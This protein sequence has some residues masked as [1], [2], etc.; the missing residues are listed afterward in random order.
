VNDW[1]LSRP[2]G[3]FPTWQHKTRLYFNPHHHHPFF[4]VLPS[5]VYLYT[6]MVKNNQTRKEIRKKEQDVCLCV[7]GGGASKH[8]LP[9]FFFL[10]RVFELNYCTCVYDYLYPIIV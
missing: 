1:R 8:L 2:Q 9:G 7:W 5:F 6:R 10:L 3:R 4:Y